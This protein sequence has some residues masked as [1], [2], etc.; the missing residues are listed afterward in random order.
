MRKTYKYRIYLTKGQRR[1]LEGQLETCRWV[2]NET[3]A[4]RKRAYEERGVRLRL[5]DTQAMLPVW[6]L[7]KPELK[8]V[9]SQVLQNVQVRVDLAFQ[10]FFRRVREG[11]EEPGFPRFKGKGRYDSIT[12]PQYGKDTGT[13]LKGDRLILSKVGAVYVIL[14]RPVEGT[15]KT[16][17]VSRS[18]TGKWFVCFSCEVEANELHP[19]SEV[20]GVDV[21]LASFA[22]FSDGE[23]IDNPRFYRRDEDDLKRVQKRKDAAKLAQDWPEN[24]KQKAILAKIHERI[25]NRRSD[26]AHKRSRE[27]VDRYQLIVFEQLAPQEMGARKGR[28][29]RKSIMDVAWTQFIEMTVSKAAEAGR[30][31]ILVDP[32]NTTKMCSQCGKLVAKTLSDRTHSCPHCGLVMD[33]D[34]NAAINILQRGLQL[35]PT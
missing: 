28:S 2:Y 25:A 24:T 8:G 10:A 21:G 14:H 15:P 9:Q 23:K 17:T 7:T 6:K 22:T 4:E 16:V 34:R 33:R 20:V 1:L 18:R 32:H 35:F 12:Y 27:L 13:Y 31:V 3:L 19:S 26:F 30:R 11:A 5:Y 29:L